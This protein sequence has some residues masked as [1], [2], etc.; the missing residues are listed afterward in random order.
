MSVLGTSSCSSSS[1]FPISILPRVATPVRLPA[2]LLRLVTRPIL[3]G[4]PPVLNTIGMVA[5]AALAARAAGDAA[6]DEDRHRTANQL[7]R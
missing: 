6:R 3:T 7:G 2:G 4:S 5:G 1:C